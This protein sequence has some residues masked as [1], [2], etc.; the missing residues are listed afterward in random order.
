MRIEVCRMNG[1]TCDAVPSATAVYQVSDR[2]RITAQVTLPWE[3]LGISGPPADKHLRVQLAA[4]TFYR[5]R[6]MSLGGASP[7]EAMK[8][9]ATWR[10]AML[11]GRPGASPDAN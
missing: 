9:Q 8:N 4:T 11:T 1:E 2:P 6:W 7:A 3:A 10:R 5:A